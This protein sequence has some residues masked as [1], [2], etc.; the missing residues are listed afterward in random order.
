MSEFPPASMP[1]PEHEVTAPVAPPPAREPDVTTPLVA[2]RS[3]R[4]APGTPKPAPM[5]RLISLIITVGLAWALTVAI[6][7]WLL[8]LFLTRG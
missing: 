1:E 4:P 7:A 2:Q 3:P 6:T 5:A 8:G